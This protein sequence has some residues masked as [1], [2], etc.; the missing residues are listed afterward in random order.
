MTKDKN[1]SNQTVPKIIDT[2]YRDCNF[3]HSNCLTVFGKKVGHRIF[4]DDDTPRTFIH[5]NMTNCEPPPNSNLI[6]SP[7]TI[8]ERMVVVKTE[9]I[10]IDGEKIEAKDYVDRI[11]GS[12]WEG[13]YT[14]HSTPI[15]V[16]RRVR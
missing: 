3:S 7:P 6:K 4:P 16:S 13:V 14:Y 2:E 1:F 5:C 11:H 12:Y 9:V 10:K 8:I 15:D